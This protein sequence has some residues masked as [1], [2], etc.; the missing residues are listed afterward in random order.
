[1]VSKVRWSVS[2]TLLL[3]VVLLASSFAFAGDIDPQLAAKLDSV[4]G[5]EFVRVFLRMEE[6]PFVSSAVDP[7]VNRFILREAAERS[8]QPVLSYLRTA[9]AAGDVRAINSF[10]LVNLVFAEARADK[11]KAL[12]QLP[13]V[14]YVYEDFELTLDRDVSRSDLQAD[15][16]LW[17]H[18]G[19]VFAPEVWEKGFQGQGITV[20]VA[21]TGVDIT[22]PEL[23][24]AMGGSP[25][26]HEGYW[27]EFDDIGN[28]VPGTMPHDTD[29]HGTHVS[30]T[31]GARNVN[32]MF[33][34]APQVTLAH[35]LVIPFGSGSWAQVIGGFQWVAE[36]GF[37]I[38]NGSF[39]ANTTNSDL[40]VATDHL[41]ASGVVPVFSNGNIRDGTFPP[42]TP[43]NT[44]SALAVGMY[45]S[46]GNEGSLNQGGIIEYPGYIYD[47]FT[48]IKPD[49]SAPGVTIFSSISGGGYAYY[50]GTS[51]SSPHVA[52]AAALLLSANPSLTVQEVK[53]VLFSTTGGHE[54][55]SRFGW[56]DIP[57]KDIHFG[58]GRVNAL[59]AVEAVPV[60]IGPDVHVFGTV[61]AETKPIAGATVVFSGPSTKVF[62]TDANGEYEGSVEEG[63]YT[64]TASATSFLPES[65]TMTLVNAGVP[66]E[67][68][69][70]LLP[71][72]L[73]GVLG[74]VTDGTAGSPL[75]GVTVQALGTNVKA[76]TDAEGKYEL[77]LP[78][79]TV[80]LRFDKAGY[81]GHVEEGVQVVPE[82]TA[83]V[84]LALDYGYRTLFGTVSDEDGGAVGGATVAVTET[85]D[86]TATDVGG[87]FALDLAAGTYTLHVSATGFVSSALSVT[88][89][90]GD[91]VEA[92]VSLDFDAGSLAG[93]VTSVTLSSGTDGDSMADATGTPLA[94]AIV[95]IPALDMETET[96][97]DGAYFFERVPAGDWRVF[98]AHEAHYGQEATVR[99]KRDEETTLNVV[100]Q[101]LGGSVAF[102]NSFDTA[103][104]QAAW[105]FVDYS[106]QGG[107]QFT[108]RR[109]TSEPF[110]AWNGQEGLSSG[111]YPADQAAGIVSAPF[112]IAEDQSVLTFRMWAEIWGP[113]HAFGVFVYDVADGVEEPVYVYNVSAATN[114]F[115]EVNVDLSPWAG[116]EVTVEFYVESDFLVLA[117]DEG[118]FIDDVLVGVADDELGGTI[119]GS[120]IDEATGLPIEGAT[121]DVS[122]LAPSGDV[123]RVS[124]TTTGPDGVYSLAVRAGGW[125]VQASKLP[126]YLPGDHVVY[127]APGEEARA[128]LELS[129]N[130]APAAVKGLHASP[131]DTSASLT[132]EANEEEDLS[133]YNIYRSLDGELFSRI[134]ATEGTSFTARG[135]QN[136]Y[137]YYFQVRS[138]DAYGFESEA[139]DTVEVV[140]ADSGPKVDAFD[141]KPRSLSRGGTVEVSAVLGHAVDAEAVLDVRLQAALNG[142]LLQE[143]VFADQAL[144]EFST[145]V[146][147]AD[148]FGK[149]WAPN[150]YQMTLSVTDGSGATVH[151]NTV[152]IA[153]LAPLPRALSFLLGNNPFNPN[154]ESQRL[155]YAVPS[156]GH[157]TMAVYTLDGQKLRTL[158]DER[159]AAG[160][161]VAFWDGTDSKGQVVLSGMYVVRT[162]FTDADGQRHDL[163]RHSVVVK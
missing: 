136:G 42:G 31:V 17:D 13:G 93:V 104:E 90:H 153:L 69:F 128:N 82:H 146:S 108:D 118:V 27:G 46:A 25:P 117:N 10:W 45:D 126:H 85:G 57:T 47:E 140:P 106:G 141:V 19:A 81:F 3:A 74:T 1:M 157:V 43:G 38:I 143:W 53:D 49:I 112:V 67:N 77:S 163:T 68:Y 123:V 145:T 159:K 122:E 55:D 41:M 48:R 20:V 148:V 50:N 119:S 149:P 84:D 113:F 111:W 83:Q 60:P 33:G 138:V 52:G 34:V 110:S 39:G 94:G 152:N 61:M 36:Q 12:A 116:R 75:A 88:V 133:G 131:G 161:Y 18:L 139:S 66:V 97:A 11:V 28:L 144:G 127:V 137:T 37:D 54:E 96:G 24:G 59:R 99:I 40:A 162:R 160:Q 107:W 129:A 132:W 72:P 134:G 5:S 86:E 130:T 125:T 73:G 100:L 44:P 87:G 51:M 92:D 30:G 56:S 63:F 16:P 64:I 147:T 124:Q 151:S 29:D 121:I 79:G 26:F 21:D 7:E 23:T 58:W 95:S 98:V 70:V 135:L 101:S 22:H 114:G 150:V 15:A 65:R 115:I 78:E 6:R 2:F 155:E 62:T 80:S 76:T 103:A 89:S 156:E 4:D 32:H 71:A 102:R 109:S 9:Q 35:A 154:A 8:Q 142:K 158:V 120:V 14:A 91:V 105:T